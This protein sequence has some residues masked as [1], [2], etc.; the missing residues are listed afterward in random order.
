M[1]MEQNILFYSACVTTLLA[2]TQSQGQS[3]IKPMAQEVGAPAINEPL[4][5]TRRAAPWP[6]AS[7]GP[8]RR[9][10]GASAERGNTPPNDE[11]CSVVPELLPIGGSLQRSGTLVD[12]TDTE[13]LGVPTVWEGFTLDACADVTFSWCGSSA[14][15]MDQ[16]FA[17]ISGDCADPNTWTTFYAEMYLT[18]CDDGIYKTMAVGLQPGNYLVLIYDLDGV[19]TTY[20]LEM[21][22]ST[23]AAAPANDLCA[24]ITPVPLA[25]GSPLTFTGTTIAATAIDDYGP[26]WTG[27]TPP[28]VWY[29]FTLADCAHVT[30]DFCAPINPNFVYTVLSTTCQLNTDLV[31]SAFDSE[32]CGGRTTM[33]FWELAAGTYY[34]PVYGGFYQHTIQVVAEPCGPYCASWAQS[35]VNVYEKISNVTFAGIDNASTSGLGY[36]DFTDLSGLVATGGTYPISI[37]LSNSYAG[38][39]A[40]V[41]IDFDQ[42]QTFQTDEL[43]FT[44]PAGTGPFSGSIS[45]PLDAALGSTRM[46]V[47]MHDSDTTHGPNNTPCGMASYGQVE[48]YTVMI[49]S[50]MGISADDAP[51]FNV[52][53]DPSNGEF[54]I[55]CLALEGNV[56]VELMDQTGR[57]VLQ[58]WYVIGTTGATIHI[59]SA[60]GVAAGSYFLRIHS[61]EGSAVRRI[62]IR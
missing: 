23:C 22:A 62:T 58:E 26:D 13:E 57:L 60:S 21:S 9:G 28:T 7:P 11:A 59:G 45:V 47:R 53:P 6:I 36:E 31:Y 61:S 35:A 5:V 32:Q 27:F 14:M 52:Y 40:F 56:R 48:D 55:Q 38:D 2:T 44:V 16:Y 49:E 37:E 20:Q 1:N 51:A 43:V 12:A 25:P 4:S 50:G 34:L 33:Q 3:H 54:T 24:N 17:I 46:R 8:E 18:Q 30:I 15:F 10:Y 42:D 41:W 29:A 39:Q 19:L